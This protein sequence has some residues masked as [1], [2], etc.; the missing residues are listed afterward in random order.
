MAWAVA[1]VAAVLLVRADAKRD[2]RVEAENKR[3]REHA[4]TIERIER[5][6]TSK[7]DDDAD[8]TWLR[9]RG[10]RGLAERD[11]HMRSDR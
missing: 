6:D 2:A 8:R 7:G 10:L 4:K 1:G 11:S 9:N 5:A 3:L